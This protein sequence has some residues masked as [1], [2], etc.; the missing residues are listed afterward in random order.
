LR[1]CLNALTDLDYPNYEVIVVNDGST[2]DTAFIAQDYPVRLISQPNKG[3]SAARNTGLAA[4]EGEIVAYIDDDAFPHRYW[5]RYLAAAFGRAAH[6]GIGGPNL[7][8]PGDGFVAECVAAAP[9]NPL[10]VLLSDE[11][12]EH[13]PGCNMAYRKEALVAI[14][15]FDP[16][17]R[18]AG[19]DV[20]ICWRLQD[21][22]STIGYCPTAVV[23]HHRRNS[24]RAYWKQ[25]YGYGKAEAQLED[26][27]PQRCNALGHIGWAGRIYGCGPGLANLLRQRIYRG[28]W[29]TA[30]FQSVH[31]P[32][33]NLA[34]SLLAMPEWY[35]VVVLFALL[36]AAGLLW[37]PL[38]L[39]LPLLALAV[40][41]RLAEAGIGAAR[42]PVMSRTRGRERLGRW[43]VTSFLHLSQPLARLCGRVRHGLTPWRCRAPARS[44][45]PRR[46]STAIW[47]ERWREPETWVRDLREAISREG[48]RVIDGGPYDRWDLE[49][50]GG[51]LA[52]ARLLIA[53]EDHG[54]GRQY[55]R[56]G[57]WPKCSGAGL[58]VT[59]FL[60]S[61][62]GAAAT[63]AAWTAAVVFAG[64]TVF[65]IARVAHEAGR[66]L[67]VLD[68]AI[69]GLTNSSGS[70]ST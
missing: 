65:V 37:E 44:K 17:F 33:A 9:G 70:L 25:Q 23:W 61:V 6:V 5:L 45:L 22:G 18:A 59:A 8:P 11:L 49:V 53:V 2:D 21:R 32:P 42:A 28:V 15:G 36:S 66:A 29:G 35:L 31:S 34:L 50:P 47:S 51:A 26:K 39:A 19:D 16:R 20:D 3:L 52:R 12:A 55:V 54:A 48:V 58:A 69:A 57:L 13:I 63:S 56:L 1:E 64:A 43:L 41:A 10:H 27:W 67:A 30:P 38:L 46:W 14:G 60:A 4:S 24:I 7:S 62:A 40:A 68:R